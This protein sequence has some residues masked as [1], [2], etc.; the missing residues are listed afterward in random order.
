MTTETRYWKRMGMR[1]TKEFALEAASKMQA[2]ASYHDDETLEFVQISYDSQSAVR[3]VELLFDN[4]DAGEDLDAENTVLLEAMKIHKLRGKKIRQF[5]KEARKDI[6]SFEDL[7]TL[8][9]YVAERVELGYEEA[10]AKAQYEN[11]LESRINAEA[12]VRWQEWYDEQVIALQKK[13]GTYK[14]S[15][16]EE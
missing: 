10:V 11:E 15:D 14:E 1:V 7:K 3:E 12:D 4:P 16:E 13:Y 5:R 2:A 8:D 9:E 6:G